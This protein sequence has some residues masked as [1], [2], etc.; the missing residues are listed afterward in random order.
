ME[1]VSWLFTSLKEEKI[2]NIENLIGK[3]VEFL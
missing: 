3:F 2:I 1:A